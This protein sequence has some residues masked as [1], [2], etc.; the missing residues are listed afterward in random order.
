MFLGSLAKHLE[1]DSPKV[2]TISKQLLVTL[3]TPSEPVQVAVAQCLIPLMPMLV[4][5]QFTFSL[6][7]IFFMKSSHRV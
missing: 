4:S 2:K 5:G 3:D 1:A 7:T 6:S